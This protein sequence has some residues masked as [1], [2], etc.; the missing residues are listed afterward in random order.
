MSMGVRKFAD[1]HAGKVTAVLEALLKKAR[2]GR[3][4]SF[5]FVAE[6][7]GNPE[8]LY[9]VVGRH[10]SDPSRAIGPLSVMKAKLIELATAKAADPTDSQLSG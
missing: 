10:R 1:P 9:G 7:L 8:A 6:E 5:S 3:L 4:P 2:A